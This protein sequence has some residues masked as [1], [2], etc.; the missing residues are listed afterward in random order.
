MSRH[1]WVRAKDLHRHFQLNS[2]KQ[3]T[4]VRDCDT[5]GRTPAKLE[6]EYGCKAGRQLA[7]DT[8][9]VRVDLV[10]T[11]VSSACIVTRENTSGICIR[12]EIDPL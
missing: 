9:S 8:I 1:W 10:M 3:D 11:F 12:P 4:F 7:A 2:L 5:L 6:A